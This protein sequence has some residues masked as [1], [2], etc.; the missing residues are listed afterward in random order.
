M[1]NRWGSACRG[2]AHAFPE[3]AEAQE[4]VDGPRDV[5]RSLVGFAGVAGVPEELQESLLHRKLGYTSWIEG[6]SYALLSKLT[7]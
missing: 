6:T 4:S 3:D 7:Y 2:D 5:L 1:L